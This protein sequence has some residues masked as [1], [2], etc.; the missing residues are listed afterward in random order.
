[1]GIDQPRDDR[2]ADEVHD[3]RAA[4]YGDLV[5]SGDG[6]DVPLLDEDQGVPHRL[7]S[8]SVDECRALEGDDAVAR[9]APGERQEQRKGGALHFGSADV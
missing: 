4:R 2:L 5:H 7:A 9:R 8:R 6:L 1:M 3:L